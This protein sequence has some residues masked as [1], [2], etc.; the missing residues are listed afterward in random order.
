MK[1]PLHKRIIIPF[2]VVGFYAIFLFAD[3]E[4]VTVKEKIS[5]DGE[6]IIEVFDQ[7]NVNFESEFPFNMGEVDVQ[8]AIH[9]MSHQK[10]IADQKWGAL[11]LTTKRVKRLIQ[12]VEVNKK[13]YEHSDLYISI[14][15]DW[16]EGNFKYV[17]LDHNAVWRLLDG[18]IGEASGI[19]L[20]EEEMKFINE[21]FD[22][23]H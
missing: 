10:V 14:L 7:K 3:K 13:E 15:T 11:P 21:N 19:A 12:V 22:I 4:N 8:Q 20:P 5:S 18:T 6:R 17:D 2:L 9:N 1:K 23:K 16:A